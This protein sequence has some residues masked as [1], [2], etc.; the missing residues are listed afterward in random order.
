MRVTEFLEIAFVGVI[1]LMCVTAALT[2]GVV[3]ILD[4]IQKG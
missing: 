2:W 1:Q 3:S 4:K